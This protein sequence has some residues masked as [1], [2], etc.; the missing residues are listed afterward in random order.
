MITE[1]EQRLSICNADRFANLCRLYL[2]YKYEIINS[3]GFVLGKEKSKKGTPDNFIP[4]KDFYIFNEITTT[5]KKGLLPKLKQ[6][7]E[8]C[9]KQT[10]VPTEK[11]LKI[12][13]ICNNKITISIQ[14]ELNKHKNSF[15]TSVDLEIIGIDAFSTIIFKEYPSIAKELGLTIDTGQILEVEEFVSQ[16]EKSKFATPLS[17][18]FFNRDKELENGTFLIQNN[19]IMIISGQ[20]GVG[21]TKFS[22]ELCTKFQKNNS[23]YKIKYIKAN[24]ILDIW[25]DLKVQL[26]QDKNYLIVVDDANKL[27]SNLDLIIN[28]Q[29]SSNKRNL[30]LIFTVRNYVKDEIQR[31]LK[32]YQLIELKNFDRDELKKILKSSDFN[33]SDFYI[34]KIYSIS[35]GNPR[36]AIMAALAGIN[37]DIEKINNA[38]LIMEEYFSSINQQL[39]VDSQLIKTAG[40]LSLF[41]TIDFGHT[42]SIEEI[43]KYFEIS[44]NEL[45][46]NLELLFKYEIA[47]EFNGS[48]KIADQILGEYIFYSVFIKQKQIPFRLLLDLYVEEN[49]FSLVKLLTPIVIN[50]GFEQVKILIIDDIKT[51]WESINNE[52]KC[53]KFLKDFWFYL[54][55]ESLLYIHKRIPQN[56]ITELNSLSFEIYN[57]N[58]IETYDDII[59]EILVNFQQLPDKFIFSLELLIRY[60][61]LNPINFSKLL[62]VFT[63]SFTYKKYDHNLNYSTQS[64]LFEFLYEKV[65]NDE[66]I[67]YSKIILFIAHEYLTD[68]FQS[69]VWDGDTIYTNQ[70]PTYLSDEQKAFRSKLWNFIFDCYKNENLKDFVLAFFEQNRYAHH[71]LQYNEVISFDKDLIVDFFHENF[72]PKPNFRETKIVH[73]FFKNLDSYKIK[74]SKKLK[75]KF[76]NK[77]VD[78]WYL[79]NERAEDKRELLYQYVKNFDFRKYQILLKQIDVIN[80][81]KKEYFEGYSTIKDSIS[82]ILIEVSKTDFK[83]FLK[84]LQELFKYEYSEYL[85]L[86]MVFRDID[87]DDFKSKEI[88]NLIM[89]NKIHQGCIV[90]FLLSLPTDFITIQD[91]L[92][93]MKFLKD[94][95]TVW[96]NFIEDIFIKFKNL[97][98]KIEKELND[99]LDCLI[100]KSNHQNFFVHTD[101]FKYLYNDYNHIFIN[102]LK[103]IESIYLALDSKSRQFDY[104]LETLKLILGK[105]SKFI[106]ALLE[107]TFDDKTFI[108]RND[109]LENN[110][111]RLWDLENRNEVFEDIVKFS[112]KFPFFFSNVRSEVSTIFQGSG[113]N[114]LNFLYYL[115]NKTSDERVMRLLFNIV[116]SVF[117]KSKYDF[118]DII[119]KKN[120]NI[121]FFRRL[122]FYPGDTVTV[123]SRIPKVRDEIT[124]YEELKNYIQALNK[125]EYLEHLNFIEN[126]IN[127]FK[128]E[129]EWERKHEFL[130]EW[131]I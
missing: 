48:Y 19:D 74:Y 129:I 106:N 6:D 116:V 4:I 77:E 45:I 50:Y 113:E 14:E 115:V 56:T 51:K 86:G 126:Q 24:G 114:G 81:H 94:E 108:S 78:L 91:Y 38:S 66:Y 57:S 61:L 121:D 53:L 10:S 1:I 21:K 118:L 82:Y 87:Y 71:Y 96:I 35:K 76:K 43:E 88:R 37:G 101:F 127:A 11:I 34:D 58:R 120:S 128:A 111:K 62:K 30:K 100:L 33:I 36:I 9:F 98:I 68:S 85:F 60:G 80:K 105:N 104:N 84:V 122:D 41:R 95:K 12:I 49:K 59:I 32:D 117:D 29:N 46:E 92:V 131:S 18:H 2:S 123:N 83:L 79:L 13:L 119:L 15:N 16:Y 17:N 39:N 107:S 112:S 7:I 27:K 25:E 102:R 54:P 65:Q 64:K 5:D 109:F 52:T 93:L 31:K 97:N 3:T 28:F 124:T 23:D 125:I 40:I 47:D 73:R 103:D 89:E 70:I 8:H 20:A 130:S 42:K 69:T 72:L 26:I 90:S 110:F 99:V 22:L 44:K 63:Q 67:F 55:T 75:E